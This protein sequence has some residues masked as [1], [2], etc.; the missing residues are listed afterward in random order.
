M[1][2]SLEHVQECWRR[3]FCNLL[4]NR[5]FEKTND[6]LET[7][8]KDAISQRMNILY[9]HSEYPEHILATRNI[10][11]NVSMFVHWRWN[12]VRSGCC[13]IVHRWKGHRKDKTENPFAHT[14]PASA[15]MRRL[16]R[17]TL[18]YIDLHF[19]RPWASLSQSCASYA[20][21]VADAHSTNVCDDASSICYLFPCR[22]FFVN[23]P[24]LIFMNTDN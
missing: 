2:Q 15:A 20:C 21:F 8:R 22:C 4:R 24:F 16:E 6:I 10:Q 19:F 7:I 12:V 3:I 23:D 17:T 13:D 18:G 1:S 14:D 5:F 11:T 9:I